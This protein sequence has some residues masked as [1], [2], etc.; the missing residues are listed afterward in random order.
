M[1]PQPACA[2]AGYGRS[3]VLGSRSKVMNCRLDLLPFDPLLPVPG[4]FR[5]RRIPSQQFS[6]YVNYIVVDA[7]RKAVDR[8]TPQALL[9]LDGKCLQPM[10]FNAN[11]RCLSMISNAVSAA[12]RTE[13][14]GPIPGLTPLATYPRSTSS[15]CTAAWMAACAVASI[16]PAS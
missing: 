12:S 11:H 6:L 5:A 2:S 15:L 4:R 9:C 3:Y 16:I 7:K 14:Q 1:P 10:K 13:F 8:L